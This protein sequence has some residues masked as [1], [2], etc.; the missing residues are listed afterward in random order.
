MQDEYA[1]RIMKMMTDAVT[2]FDA[3]DGDVGD[4]VVALAQAYIMLAGTNG[5]L[6]GA[7]AEDFAAE[8]YKR[9]AKTSSI[10]AF[11]FPDSCLDAKHGV[12]K[13]VLLAS[14][15][16]QALDNARFR[17]YTGALRQAKEAL[18]VA[19]SALAR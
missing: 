17:S 8:A 14:A 13:D 15:K 16:Q 10:E 19:G 2:E 11:T 18:K 4:V 9:F 5:F 6:Q 1:K 12:H 7:A 3:E